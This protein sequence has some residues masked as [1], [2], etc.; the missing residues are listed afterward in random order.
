[1]GMYVVWLSPAGCGGFTG[2]SRDAEMCSGFPPR[3]AALVSVASG[4][5]G[6][7]VAWCNSGEVKE[8]GMEIRIDRIQIYVRI[9]DVW[10]WVLWSG[11]VFPYSCV[12]G[13]PTTKAST[14]IKVYL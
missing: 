13:S 2:L 8:Q 10:W 11:D 12:K 1:M 9:I 6:L 14:C 7:W 4:E 3:Q 5:K